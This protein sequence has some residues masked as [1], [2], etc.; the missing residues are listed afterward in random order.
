MWLVSISVMLAVVQWASSAGGSPRLPT[1]RIPPFFWASAVNVVPATSASDASASSTARRDGF[2][3]MRH[4]QIVGEPIYHTEGGPTGS[5]EAATTATVTGRRPG[6]PAASVRTIDGTRAGTR[7]DPRTPGE[8]RPPRRRACRR[9]GA[10]APFHGGARRA[11]PR[12]S[13]LPRAAGAGAYGHSC[14]ASGPSAEGRV[15]LRTARTT[16]PAVP[17]PE[18]WPHRRRSRGPARRGGRGSW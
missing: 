4:L 18:E 16:A 15:L 9:A 2:S 13:S 12:T 10:T 14:P 5:A 11:A 8:M 7:S 6:R 17:A 1:R 3:D